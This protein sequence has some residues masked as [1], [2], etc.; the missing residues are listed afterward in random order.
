MSGYGGGGGGG[1]GNPGN[2]CKDKLLA[3]EAAIGESLCRVLRAPAACFVPRVRSC[4]GLLSCCSVCSSISSLWSHR[5]RAAGTAGQTD[6][7]AAWLAQSDF[8]F[9]LFD[10]Q[11]SPTNLKELGPIIA[12][13]TGGNAVPIVRVGQNVAD[14]I[15]YALD[16]GAKGVVVPMVNTRAEA[17]ACVASVKYHPDGVRSNAGMRGEW[18]DFDQGS[19]AGYREYM[20]FFNENVLICPMIETTEAVANID[21]IASVPGV[22]VCLIGPSDLSITHDVPL[23]Y[24]SDK[25]AL[26]FCPSR[27]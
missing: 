4:S 24:T 7:S 6:G 1:G 22:D 13:T 26:V 2:K 3:G 20:D 16:A 11:H 23:D 5:R 12:T 18:G 15:C 25:C 27:S 19:S 8:D 10:T 17:E 14:Q 9:L 21:A